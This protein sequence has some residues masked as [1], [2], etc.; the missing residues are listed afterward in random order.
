MCFGKAWCTHVDKGKER[1]IQF[2]TT[3]I[4]L[5]WLV[6]LVQNTDGDL[7]R[8]TIRRSSVADLERI[9]NI[10]TPKCT[11]FYTRCD[12]DHNCTGCISAKCYENTEYS[13]FHIQLCVP[14]DV[15]RF[16]TWAIFSNKSKLYSKEKPLMDA[17]LSD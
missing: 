4:L 17:E 12:T 3:M 9:S 11:L 13:L 8:F 7:S 15:R 5:V 10:T 1:M 2:R 16:V 14:I 6:L